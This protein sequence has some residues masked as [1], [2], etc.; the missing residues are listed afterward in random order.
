MTEA[1]DLCQKA[2]LPPPPH[3]SK[4]PFCG[5]SDTLGIAAATE[6]LKALVICREDDGPHRTPGMYGFAPGTR[7]PTLIAVKF[8]FSMEIK[9]HIPTH[10]VH[11][12][13]FQPTEHELPD[14]SERVGRH[15][16]AACPYLSLGVCF[17]QEDAAL[18]GRGHF[19]PLAEEKRQGARPPVC[20]IR[21]P[22]GRAEPPQHE[23]AKARDARDA[24]E[25]RGGACTQRALRTA[26]RGSDCAGAAS[27][28]SRKRLP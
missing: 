1:T 6:D 12:G 10:R 26:A 8:L 3:S 17:H 14:S 21:A 4:D 20:Q 16:Q 18:A 11:L 28:T 5:S 15:L 27:P 9:I 24:A 23:E 19:C 22:P 13:S 7:D 2:R 25:A